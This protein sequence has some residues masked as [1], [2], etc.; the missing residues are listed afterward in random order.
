MKER[1][2]T[3]MREAAILI[4]CALAAC[5]SKTDAKG[6]RMAEMCVESSNLLKNEASGV[7]P[8][9]FRLMVKNVLNSCSQACDAG[10][11]ASCTLLDE[12]IGILCNKAKGPCQVLCDTGTGTLKGRACA[13]LK[14]GGGDH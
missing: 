3:F 1:K 8:S 7:D 6:K 10:Q 14:G 12:H 13:Q 5:S 4:L 2:P 9:T 11:S